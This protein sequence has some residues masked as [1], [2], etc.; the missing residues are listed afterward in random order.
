ML[1]SAVISAPVHAD[2]EIPGCEIPQRGFKLLLLHA[3]FDRR[4]SLQFSEDPPRR[5]DLQ[6]EAVSE[7]AP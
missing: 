6:E 5:R 2:E 4:G 3:W 1:A 7:V